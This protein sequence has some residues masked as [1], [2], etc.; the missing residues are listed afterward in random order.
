MA[1][2]KIS[3]LSA[4]TSPAAG[5]LFPVVD[6]SE[7]A[8][9]DKNKSIAFGTLFRTLPDGTVGAPALGF[10]SDVGTSGI[11]R[12]A[13]NEVAFTNNSVF[14]GKFTT[15]GFQLGDGTAAAQLHLFSSDTT[16]QV[17]IENTDAGLDT[18][19]DLV[20]YR[21]S[22]SPAANDNLGN[23]EF[24]GEDSAGNTHAYAQI[25]A[26]ISDPTDAAEDGI[27]DLITSNGGINGALVRLLGSFVGINQSAPEFSL[28]VGND[29]TGTALQVESDVDDPASAADVTLYHHRDGG[30]GVAEDILSSVFFRGNN[31]NAT[32]AA[33]DYAAIEGSIVDPTDTEEDGRLEL[34]IAVAGTLTPQLKIEP[35]SV[36]FGNGQATAAD[37]ISTLNF[38]GENDNAT[39]ETVNYAAIEATIVDPTD[40]AEVGRLKFQVQTAGTLTTQLEIDGDKIGFF[41]TAAAGQPSAIADL[42]VTATTGTLPTPDGSIT[43]ADAASPTNAELL[44]Y[45]A[46]LEAKLE[47]ALAALRTLGL[48]AT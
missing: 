6:V 26:Q 43:I 48:V 42:S 35:L 25:F 41:G 34:Q 9:V 14:T 11:Y 47:S 32:P 8:N 1:S 36:S 30:A 12:T 45:C 16:D 38:E 39:P 20:L 28:H 18:A 2:R 29:I 10:L 5:V 13:A 44:E 27:L 31:D 22:A 17:I 3:D 15:D 33:L 7:A 24:R 19:P 4:L 37:V 21:N 40:T 23:I 46:E